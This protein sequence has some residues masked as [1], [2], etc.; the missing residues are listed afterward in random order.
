ME[1]SESHP[2]CVALGP[3]VLAGSF[4]DAD[5]RAVLECWRDGHMRLVVTRGLL[6]AYLGVL[7]SMGVS[8]PRLRRWALWFTSRDAT[9]V[10]MEVAAPTII[11]NLEQAAACNICHIIV[12]HPA[13]RDALS[14]DRQVY[15][16]RA[17]LSE[18]IRQ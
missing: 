4:F 9:E 6:S 8:T 12:N 13:W 1:G 14:L 17:F 16:A 18:C 3:D 11:A 5:C 10:H 7:R 2:L 15:F